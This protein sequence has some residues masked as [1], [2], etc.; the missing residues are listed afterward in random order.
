LVEPSTN[1]TKS[2]PPSFTDETE[3]KECG[4]CNKVKPKRK[5][6]EREWAKED[7]GD[8][9][10]EKCIKLDKLLAK[11][12]EQNVLPTIREQVA[13][14]KAQA[15]E[16]DSHPILGHS[17]SSTKALNLMDS[18]GTAVNL[19]LI[20]LRLRPPIEPNLNLKGHPRPIKHNH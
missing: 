15:E 17:R 8:R 9:Q 6:C 18:T 4:D 11:H 14:T 10:C 19:L 7:D 1:E 13:S 3:T 5:F 20:L 12:R 2:I 16:E